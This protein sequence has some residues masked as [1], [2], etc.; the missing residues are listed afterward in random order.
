[1]D[2]AMPQALQNLAPSGFSALQLEH[3]IA[4]P[5]REPPL[6]PSVRPAAKRHKAAL[7]PV[8]AEP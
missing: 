4:R 2:M 3:R 1:M 8:I 6:Q 5:A 7:R